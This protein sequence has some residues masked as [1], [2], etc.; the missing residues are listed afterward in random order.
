MNID[1]ITKLKVLAGIHNKEG[2]R[3]D[4]ADESNIS[5]TGTEK[6]QYMKKHNIQPGTSEWFKLWFSKPK[7][8][9]EDP[10]PKSKT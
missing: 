2:D 10:T 3:V 8:T 5:I 1:E 4:S 6:G 7:L 9:G